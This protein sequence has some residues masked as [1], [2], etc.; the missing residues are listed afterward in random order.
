MNNAAC[1]ARAR[2]PALADY[3]L[4]VLD[5]VYEINVVA[6]LG[7]DPA[8]AARARAPTARSSTS[9]PTPRSRPTGLGRLRLVEGRARAARRTCSRAEQPD[10]RVYWVDPGDMRTQMHQEAFPGEDISDRPLPETSVPGL[11]RADRGRPAERPLPR[12][13]EPATAPRRAALSRARRLELEATEPPERARRRTRRGAP[14]RR[15]AAT[16]TSTHARFA[17]PAAAPRRRATSS[18]STPRRRSP[19]A[20]D[21]VAPGGRRVRVHLSTVSAPPADGLWLVELRVPAGPGT[22]AVRRPRRRGCGSRSP[23]A[24]A[25]R[26]RRAASPR[27]W[28]AR[29]APAAAGLLDYLDRAR[30]ADPLPLRRARDW[31]IAATRTSS[32]PS[33]AAP[34]CRAPAARSRPSSSPSSSPRASSV[35]PLVLHTGVSSLETTS[36][37]TPS[38]SGCPAATARH[39]NA[40]RAAGGRVVAVGT[41]VVRALETAARDG[42]A[43][44][45]RRRLDRARRHAR[46]RACASSTGC[47]PAGT[48]RRRR[49]D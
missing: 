35:A 7:A 36:R 46:A 4:E 10:V 3:P 37:R 42:T 18:S 40:V 49:T 45:T 34:R 29:L 24:A 15:P 38:G 11:L 26:L 14:A 25:L 20:L 39:V 13:R 21:A 5:A 43:S 22:A 30:P 23:A 1:S 6:P 19:A 2:S 47:S 41:T 48:S 8:G 28:V 9:R 27:L 16:A 12:A 33:P 44:R 31:P 17:R 32:R